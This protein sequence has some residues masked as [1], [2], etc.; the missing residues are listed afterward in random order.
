MLLGQGAAEAGDRKPRGAGEARPGIKPPGLGMFGMG[1]DT[2]Q[3]GAAFRG[4]VGQPV[5]H[6]LQRCI[7]TLG[8][9]FLSKAD[10][11]FIRILKEQFPTAE[12]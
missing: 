6:R 4:M 3:R 8:D 1:G 9:G 12:A 10:Q 7:A 11:L 5:Q 2:Q